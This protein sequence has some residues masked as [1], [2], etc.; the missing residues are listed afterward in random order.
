ML[1]DFSFLDYVWRGL[2]VGTLTSTIVLAVMFVILSTL[3]KKASHLQMKWFFNNQL[4]LLLFVFIASFAFVAIGDPELAAGCFNQFVKGSSSFTITRIVSGAWLLSIFAFSV[5]DSLR[6]YSSI[7]KARKFQPVE[8]QVLQAEFKTTLSRMCLNQNIKL[9]TTTDEVSP[10]VW[11]FFKYKVVVPELALNS[12]SKNALESI[13]AHE[14]VHVRD[15]DA[16]WLSFELLCRRLM[17]FNPLSY[18]LSRKHIL[19]IE[20][21]ADE[22]AVRKGGVHA[23]DLLRSLVEVVSVCKSGPANPMILSAS[24]SFKEIKERMES[25]SR[26]DRPVSSGVLFYS[27][28]ILSILLSLGFSVAQ[29]KMAVADLNEKSPAVGMM[30]SQLKHEKIIESWLNI[31]PAPNKCEE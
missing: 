26:T 17:F 27:A 29:A 3:M 31:E 18:L 8:N 20:M 28:S 19:T 23:G 16:L 30:C 9:Y 4:V 7:L 6:V 14:L 25:L 5:L 13:L 1:N 2:V 24:R 11:G 12:L 10:F 21:A 15:R 22:E